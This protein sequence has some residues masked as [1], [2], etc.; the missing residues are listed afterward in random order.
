MVVSARQ[1]TAA[2]FKRLMKSHRLIP[3]SASPA[4]QAK[5]WVIAPA[6]AGRPAK[7]QRRE[8]RRPKSGPQTN[9]LSDLPHSSVW[10]FAI[11]TPDGEF[12]AE[13][14]AHGLKRLHFPS[15]KPGAAKETFSPV[16]AA[17]RRWHQLTTAAV[18]AAARGRDPG[19]LPPLDWSL[20]TDFQR[21]VWGAL[22][23]IR[24]G[25]ARS[26][27]EIARAIGRPKAVRAVG[28]ACG[29]NPLPL[30]VPCHRVLA[31]DG[32]IGGF[33]G[34]LEWK[35]MLLAREGVKVRS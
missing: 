11:A 24:A 20:G 27:G 16:P 31:A 13:Y 14:S 25:R 18:K 4:R 29:A 12:V 10:S 33:S 30:L 6:A 9:A 19:P 1:V 32:H 23:K 7:R 21:R 22:R 34:G 28:G 8:G 15:R 35:R 2:A 5:T 26:Y 17:V 3:P